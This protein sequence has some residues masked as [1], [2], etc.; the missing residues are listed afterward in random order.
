MAKSLTVKTFS[1]LKWTTA[2]TVI[3][4]ILQVGYNIVIAR[5]LPPQDFG[6]IAMAMVVLNF[7][8]YIILMGL[9]QALIQKK[10]LDTEE[11]RA[12]FTSNLILGGFFFILCQILAPFAI[13][14]IDREEIIM[15]VRLMSLVILVECLA[16]VSTSLIR[17]NFQ[18]KQLALRNIGSYIIAYLGIGITMAFLGFRVYSLVAA[19]LS[20]TIINAILSYSIARHSMIPIFKWK[21]YSQLFSFGSKIT[22]INFLEFLSNALD[23]FLIGRL[24][25]SKTLGL[26]N[27]AYFLIQLPMFHLT[28]SISTVLFPSLSKIQ[29][30]PD[31]L[32][33]VYLS[34]I[35]IVGFAMIPTFAGVAL[36]AEPI[37]VVLLGAK[38]GEAVPI[39]QILAFAAPLR[40]INHFAGEI[41]NATAKLGPKLIL[42]IVAISLLLIMFYLL[43][44]L[45]VIGFALAVIF[46]DIFKLIGYFFLVKKIVHFKWFELWQAFLPSLVTTVFCGVFILGLLK[47]AQYLS[48]PLFISFIICMLGGILGLLMGL[49]FKTNESLRKVIADNFEKVYEKKN[50]KNQ[51]IKKI[52]TF[53]RY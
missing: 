17:R 38:W 37:I 21:Y 6:I 7:G 30:D 2:S 52:V 12:A 44:P 13:Y 24:L 51:K 46:M 23:T 25:G 43:Q 4:I 32:R 27:R 41:C 45:A 26:Y 47:A 9:P 49:L 39:L 11:I 42:N 14:I 40:A 50:I 18:F 28:R 36:A 15:I 3:N 48:L 5:L 53:L 33:K 20:Q 10:E 1:G 16:S 35:T 19:S 22:L 8:R 31:R 29:N 34:A